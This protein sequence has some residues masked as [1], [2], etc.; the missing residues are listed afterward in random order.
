VEKAHSRVGNREEKESSFGNR[1]DAGK[2][3]VAQRPPSGSLAQEGRRPGGSVLPKRTGVRAYRARA[4][5][6]LQDT[7]EKARVS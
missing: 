7:A 4:G 5:R 3:G 2:D 1:G 6:Q